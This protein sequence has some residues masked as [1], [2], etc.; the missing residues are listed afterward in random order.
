VDL[1]T[2]TDARAVARARAARARKSHP[3]AALVPRRPSIARARLD[4]DREV[5]D[6]RAN[7]ESSI[8]ASIVARSSRAR[9]R[10]PPSL[11]GTAIA[12]RARAPRVTHR[13]RAIA[14]GGRTNARASASSD[15]VDAGVRVAMD[16]ATKREFEW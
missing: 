13:R 6:R 16:G 8:V 7:L 5:R 1:V 12:R 9:R 15:G 10:D 14:R 3:R 4:R 11:S 2:E